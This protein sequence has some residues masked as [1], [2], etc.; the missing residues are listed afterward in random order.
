MFENQAVV[1]G[2]SAPTARR[3]SRGA[4][5]QVD[6]A[7]REAARLVFGGRLEPGKKAAKVE[8]HLGHGGFDLIPWETCSSTMAAT[9]TNT[10]LMV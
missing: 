5:S 9:C 4:I 3:D 1:A 7:A 2:K 10:L 6:Q 8:G